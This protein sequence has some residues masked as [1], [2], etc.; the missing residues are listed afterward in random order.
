MPRSHYAKF[1]AKR[2]VPIINT[3][4]VDR[5][6]AQPRDSF[7]YLKDAPLKE[8]LAEAH[9]LGHRF[10]T[11]PWHNQIVCFLIGT[12]LPS[13]LFYVKMG[14]GKSAISLELIR[15]RKHMGHL[16]GAI[17]LVPETLHAD[18]WELQIKEH[19]PDL[20]YRILK[21]DHATRLRQL[22][23]P[24]DVTITTFKGL[25][26]FMTSRQPVKGKKRNKQVLDKDAAADFA[27]R[28]N[29]V[30]YDEIHRIVHPDTVTYEM[31]YWLSLASDFRYA[32]TG[33]PFGRDPSPVYNQFKLIDHGETFGNS[34]GMFKQ[35][36]FTPKQ[37]YWAG[38]QWKFNP[39]MTDDLHRVIK[40]RSITYS[41]D[42]L[43]DVPQKL[44]V[45]VPVRL[46]GEGLAYYERIVAGLKEAKGDYRSLENV[47][48]RMRQCAS[49]FIAM[50]ADDESRIE[51]E[52]K[53][54]PKLDRLSEFLQSKPDEKILVF[55][56][57]R[58][59]AR[60]I[61]GMLEEQK[62]KFARVRGGIKDP[63]AEYR[64]FLNED[65]CKV[66]L[67]NNQLGS[68]NINPQGVCRRIVVYESSVDPKRREQMEGRVERPGQKSISFIHDLIVL[69]TIEEKIR[70][71]NTQGMNLLQ[72][73]LSGDASLLPEET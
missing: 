55:H 36:F 45:R 34:V 52:F 3:L 48:T 42:E 41:L 6:L 10:T 35:V 29:F 32:L 53:D 59:S 13:F 16:K 8:L 15:Y 37:D 17:I 68:E 23:K 43:H 71:Y 9:R 22:A 44:R 5:Y 64:R 4:A 7:D 31:F 40:H 66:F 72:A 27:S 39:K 60:Y 30:V 11:D 26:S 70:L 2:G 67:L 56:E 1:I 46:R 49:G 51:V 38:L 25:E 28:F 65:S 21:G 50:R 69:G 24:T 47:F 58:P 61:E 12:L 54:N 57:F 33:S 19:T 62:I 14:G 63:G 18:S 73:I 20:S